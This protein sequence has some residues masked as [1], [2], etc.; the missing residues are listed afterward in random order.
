MEAVTNGWPTKVDKFKKLMEDLDDFEKL[1]KQYEVAK[2]E[3]DAAKKAYKPFI[4]KKN[5]KVQAKIDA[6]TKDVEA[7][8]KDEY[9]LGGTSWFFTGK[10]KVSEY[11]GIQKEVTKAK[12]KLKDDIAFYTNYIPDANKLYEAQAKLRIIEEYEEAGKKYKKLDKS[13]QTARSKIIDLDNRGGETGAYSEARKAKALWARDGWPGA[14]RSAD[15]KKLDAYFDKSARKVHASKT[16]AEHEGYYHYTWGSG[17]FNAPLVGFEHGFDVSGFGFKGA[18]KVD[19][20]IGGYGSKIRGLTRLVEKSVQDTDFWVQ[21]GQHYATLEGMLKIPYGRL[22]SMT[23]AEL[24]QFVGKV[25]QLPQFISG[26]IN[27]GGGSYAPGETVFNIFCPKGSEALYVLEDG[28]YRKMEHEMI[29]QR[30]GTYR[31]TR[32]YWGRDEARGGRKL[33]VDM[34]LRLEKGYNKFQQ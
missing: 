20:N 23:D 8:G 28:F 29:L 26:S 10:H 12:K 16:A 1:G 13:L 17:P 18:G 30:G 19:I 5:A 15:Y 11:P 4:E 32:I 31:I 24:Q 3:Y 27:K 22:A 6:L 21:S 7:L 34:E 9:D 2:A 14:S 33:F 25:E